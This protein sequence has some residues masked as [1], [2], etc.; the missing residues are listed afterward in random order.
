MWM[1]PLHLHVNQKSYYG[2]D[3]IYMLYYSL[4]CSPARAGDFIFPEDFFIHKYFY[5]HYYYKST[6]AID[7]KAVAN[8]DPK[9]HCS[10]DLHRGSLC[11]V[12]Y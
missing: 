2:Y 8:L 3:M 7:T 6:G 4:Y 1:M 5:Y 12:T 9:E 10:Y 11:I